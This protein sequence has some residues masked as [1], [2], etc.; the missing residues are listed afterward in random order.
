MAK[1]KLKLGDNYQDV[2]LRDDYLFN[3]YIV[4]HPELIKK[5]IHN[6]AFRYKINRAYFRIVNS[7]VD[8]NKCSSSS[9]PGLIVRVGLC[10]Y[11]VLYLDC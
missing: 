4:M 2:E 11:A 6:I 10:R 1:L 3:S 8:Y 7:F 9:Y 5:L